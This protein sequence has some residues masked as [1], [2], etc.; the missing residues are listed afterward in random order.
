MG[1]DFQVRADGSVVITHHG[2]QA[3]VLR[4]ARAA[5]FLE[6]VASDPQGTMAR[7][8]GNY[9]HGNERAAK[10]HPRNRL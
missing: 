5:E 6:A 3:T 4:G 7:W 8:T 9:K 10:E 2:R 1:F